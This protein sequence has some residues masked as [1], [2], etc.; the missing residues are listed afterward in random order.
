[1]RKLLRLILASAAL[2]AG[3]CA[4]TS[5]S[6]RTVEIPRLPAWRAPANPGP[7]SGLQVQIALIEVLPGVPVYCSDAVYTRVNHEWLE[8]FIAW[9]W[10]AQMALG[11]TYR[12][13]SRDC[14]KFAIGAFLA[15]TNAAANAGLDMTPLV[16]RVVVAQE[17]TFAA[18]PGAPLSRH[19]LNGVYTDRAPYYWILEPQPNGQ[20][21]PR[22]IPLE[23]YPNRPLAVI[24]GDYNP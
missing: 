11:F 20:G 16:A 5:T 12:F 1:M 24:L 6:S 14:D 4:S 18:V 7:V 9:T 15:A 17:K 23:K 2:F 3:G 8:D 21:I 13:N 22:L 19:E 10:Q